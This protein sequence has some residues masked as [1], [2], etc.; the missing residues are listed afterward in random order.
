MDRYDS[1]R[2]HYCYNGS[3]VLKNKL[4]IQDMDDLEAAE[5]ENHRDHC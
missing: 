5:R 4:N 3:S 2:D 1:A